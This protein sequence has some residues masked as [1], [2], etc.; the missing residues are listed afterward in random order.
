MA[1]GRSAKQNR[2][3]EQRSEKNIGEQYNNDR[4]K[5][6]QHAVQQASY[7]TV[8]FR[9]RDC[10]LPPEETS[11]KCGIIIK[12]NLNA[13]KRCANGYFF[14]LTS[15]RGLFLVSSYRRPP[16]HHERKGSLP[17]TPVSTRLHSVKVHQ[18]FLRERSQQGERN[19]SDQ[20]GVMREINNREFCNL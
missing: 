2:K 10:K 12:R 11:G 16:L 5:T 20:D 13:L 7:S 8:I 4:Q 3:R 14:L 18:P 15:G 19:T 9:I 6:K 1:H 17:L